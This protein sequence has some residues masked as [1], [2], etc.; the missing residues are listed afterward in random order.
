M[1]RLKYLL[2]PFL[3]RKTWIL[4][5]QTKYYV[6]AG[7]FAGILLGYNKTINPY[8]LDRP[9]DFNVGLGAIA[10]IAH[11]FNDKGAI[12]IEVGSDYGFIRLQRPVSQ[13]KRHMFTDMIKVGYTFTFAA[14][15][16]RPSNRRYQNLLYKKL[17]WN[18]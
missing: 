5:K 18:N 9:N 17:N 13:M 7:P 8:V 11:H 10:G 14:N 12:F 16:A 2:V 4:D 15:Y 3:A 1:Y 6:G